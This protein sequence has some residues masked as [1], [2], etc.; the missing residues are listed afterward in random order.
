MLATDWLA[1]HSGL[2]RARLV[3]DASLGYWY[4]LS[5][6]DGLTGNTSKSLILP[7]PHRKRHC[8]NVLSRVSGQD[9]LHNPIMATV[10]AG[11]STG[12]QL[13]P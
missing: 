1:G 10:N 12:T 4:S 9:T 11:T 6:C 3:S 8:P 13:H 5:L 2:E 7:G